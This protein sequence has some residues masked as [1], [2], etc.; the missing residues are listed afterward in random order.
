MEWSDSALEANHRQ[1]HQ[2]FGSLKLMDS[3]TD[4]VGLM[5]HWL[6]AKVRMNF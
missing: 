1:M 2:I 5:D 6:S 4:D 3:I